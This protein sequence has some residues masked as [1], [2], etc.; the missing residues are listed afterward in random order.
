MAPTVNMTITLSDGQLISQ[1]TGQ[2]KVPLFAESG[3]MFFPKG[4]NAKI[5][6]PKTQRDERAS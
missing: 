6:F 1:M 2:G 3:T 5:E 4:I